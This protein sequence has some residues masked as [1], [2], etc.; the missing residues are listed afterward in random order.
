MAGPRGTSLAILL[1]QVL[2]ATALLI[3]IS[4]LYIALHVLDEAG[5]YGTDHNP[6][7]LH[8]ACDT[9][10]HALTPPSTASRARVRYDCQMLKHIRCP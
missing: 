1:L 9:L 4:H 8:V 7:I 3:T 6:L 10:K 2:V 5:R